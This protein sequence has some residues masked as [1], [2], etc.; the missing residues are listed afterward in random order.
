[1]AEFNFERQWAEL[2]MEVTSG[3]AEWRQQ[4][5]RATFREIEAALDE[6]MNRARAKFLAD[7]AT[8][9]RAADWGEAKEEERPVCPEC[10]TR[11]QSRGEKRRQLQTAGGETVELKRHHAVC[12]KCGKAF[13]PPG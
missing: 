5:P 9:S 12:P 4:H 3:M 13:F 1:V 10:G 8:A 7:A 6:R 2:W 11:V